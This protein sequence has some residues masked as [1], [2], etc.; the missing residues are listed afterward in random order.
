MPNWVNNTLLIEAEPQVIAKIKTQLSASYETKYQKLPSDEWITETV[1]EDLSF[2]N[3]I[4][5]PA[6]K[7]DE[8]HGTHGY[9][10]GE[11]QGDTEFNWY[12]WNISN[13]GVKWDASESELVEADETS[14]QYQFNTPWGV[15]EE[16]L[17]ALSE[18]YPDVK[19]ILNFEEEQGWG[20]TYEWTNGVGIETNSYQYKCWGCDA[21][22]EEYPE[23]TEF[24]ENGEHLC[25]KQNK[26][27]EVDDLVKI[28]EESNG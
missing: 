3:I 19:F 8:Y 10:N 26:Q 25:D 15:A 24:D 2:W 7:M 5:P 16:A 14:L 22:Y 20:G 4:R 12:N 17:T 27:P 1:Q 21:Q 28:L 6:D 9:V 18:Q 11:K 13:W 23:D